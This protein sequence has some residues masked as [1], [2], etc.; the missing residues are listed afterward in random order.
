[1]FHSCFTLVLVSV[2]IGGRRDA[3]RPF[4]EGMGG[5][6]EWLMDVA[7]GAGELWDVSDLAERCTYF[8]RVRV[9]GT[10]CGAS[11]VICLGRGW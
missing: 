8:G 2:Y 1:M 4:R 6:L 7:G 10:A 3:W 5:L 9:S 11:L